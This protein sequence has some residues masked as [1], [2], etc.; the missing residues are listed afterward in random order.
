MSPQTILYKPTNSH[1]F[2]KLSSLVMSSSENNQ[3]IS[4]QYVQSYPLRTVLKTRQ[5]ILF[6]LEVCMWSRSIDKQINTSLQVMTG[7]TSGSVKEA[8]TGILQRPGRLKFLNPGIV[9]GQFYNYSLNCMLCILVGHIS[10]L[11]N[12]NKNIGLSLGFKGEVE[13]MKLKERYTYLVY[14]QITV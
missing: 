12:R 11:T 10:Q 3:Q 8:Q 9:K 1:C 13:E 4:M 7:E 14:L 2:H 6:Y 5:T